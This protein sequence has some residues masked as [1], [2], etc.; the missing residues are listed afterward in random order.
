MELAS[1][2]KNHKDWRIIVLRYFNPCGAHTSG[3]LGD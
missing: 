1:L 3:L 2:A